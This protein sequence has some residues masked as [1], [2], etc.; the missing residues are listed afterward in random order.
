MFAIRKFKIAI[1]TRVAGARAAL[2][3]QQLAVTQPNPN[4]KVFRVSIY[5]SSRPIERDRAPGALKA[6]TRTL[7]RQHV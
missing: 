4:P 1:K 3:N 2:T 7:W 6:R 5:E